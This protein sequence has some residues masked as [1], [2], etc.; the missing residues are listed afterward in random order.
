MKMR[1]IADKDGLDFIR[2]YETEVVR[3]I[4]AALAEATRR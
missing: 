4:E 3:M 2:A 1:G